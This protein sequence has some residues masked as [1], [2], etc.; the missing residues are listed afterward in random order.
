MPE[1]PGELLGNKRYRGGP[2]NSGMH[3]GTGKWNLK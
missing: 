2:V 3:L 1:T